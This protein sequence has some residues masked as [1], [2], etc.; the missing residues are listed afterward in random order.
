MLLRHDCTSSECRPLNPMSSLFWVLSAPSVTM[1]LAPCHDVFSTAAAIMESI[2]GEYVNL[3]HRERKTIASAYSSFHW[4]S[5][6]T[7]SSTDNPSMNLP[8]LYVKIHVAGERLQSAALTVSKTISSVFRLCARIQLAARMEAF[9]YLAS[10]VFSARYADNLERQ[11][12][13]KR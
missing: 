6:V 9:V 5:P 3:L 10:P 2:L 13:L 12:Y 8:A 7:L 1:P 4:L 11:M